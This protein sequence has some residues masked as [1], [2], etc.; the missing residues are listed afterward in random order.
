MA[1]DISAYN[2]QSYIYKLENLKR[3]EYP[4][5]RLKLVEKQYKGE[6]EENNEEEK[7]DG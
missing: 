2:V 3:F 5:E 4:F 6:S 1:T 7:K